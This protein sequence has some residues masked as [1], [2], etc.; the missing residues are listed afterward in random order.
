MNVKTKNPNGFDFLSFFLFLSLSLSHTKISFIS[1]WFLNL[2]QQ[3]QRRTGKKLIDEPSA[4][5][6][7]TAAWYSGWLV[8]LQREL[9]VVE[10]FF[11]HG[12][13]PLGVYDNLFAAFDSDDTC[14][15]TWVAAMVDKPRKASLERRINDRFLQPLH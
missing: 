4:L 14:R 8:R 10:E 1:F 11:S 12:N 5:L 7:P 3:N 9:V 15:A 6:S 13:V 2:L